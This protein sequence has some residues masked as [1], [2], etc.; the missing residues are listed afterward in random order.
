MFY[1]SPAPSTLE[2]GK[3]TPK[4]KLRIG[5]CIIII[6]HRH[7]SHPNSSVR[8]Y[9]K[10]KQSGAVRSILK[11]S[12]EIG[13]F[14]ATLPLLSIKADGG[15]RPAG[16][17]CVSVWR[18]G[19]KRNFASREPLFCGI[20]NFRTILGWKGKMRVQKKNWKKKKF[21]ERLWSVKKWWEFSR[22]YCTGVPITG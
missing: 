21:D 6:A 13:F 19:R 3:W 10:E 4:A 7:H 5:S 18:L 12:R 1:S 8:A 16:I 17:V 9:R 22:Q 2:R 11:V 20:S 15:G 14:C